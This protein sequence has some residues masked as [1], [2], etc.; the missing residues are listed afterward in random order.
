[1]KK[2][3]VDEYL[4]K[5]KNSNRHRN[6]LLAVILSLSMAVFFTVN[7][8]LRLTGI[9]MTG[10]TAAAQSSNDTA[11]STAETV[12]EEVTS[13]AAENTAAPENSVWGGGPSTADP[14]KTE[15]PAAEDTQ[16]FTLTSAEADGFTVTV[17]GDPSVLPY[18]AEE[19]SVSVKAQDVSDLNETQ[20]N[21]YNTLLASQAEQ[22]D[23]IYEAS[24]DE[25]DAQTKEVDDTTL[26]AAKQS[27]EDQNVVTSD[28]TA[29]ENNNSDT[30][31]STVTN[32]LFDVT[33]K[34]GD[35]A[36]E[37]KG[38][39]QVSIQSDLFKSTD[40]DLSIIHLDE[41]KNEAVDTEA[42]INT[43]EGTAVLKMDSFSTIVIANS[44]AKNMSWGD[45]VTKVNEKDG[46]NCTYKLEE[47]IDN[48]EKWVL[49]DSGDDVTI[50]LNGHHITFAGDNAHIEVKD[51]ATLTIVDTADNSST[52]ASKETVS[53]NNS[54][55]SKYYNNKAE[56]NNISES[57]VDKKQLIYYI[58]NSSVSDSD[59][60]KTTEAL[61]K[62][63]VTTTSYIS[64]N[65]NDK[66]KGTIYAENGSTVNV[67]GGLITNTAT[68]GSHDVFVTGSSTTLNVSGGYIA[69]VSS[70]QKGAGICA[71][72]GST[73]N[74]SG[75]VIA[76][77]ST[78]TGGGAVYL[79]GGN[80]NISHNAIISGNKYS[81]S[82]ESSEYSGGGGIYAINSA[83]IVI[84]G[85]YIT[86]NSYTGA[87]NDDNAT[88]FGG[89]AIWTN[90]DSEITI[91]DGQI[92]GNY[93][94]NGGGGLYIGS[95]NSKATLYLN[96]GIV[97]SNYCET[98]EGGGIRV[99]GAQ[100]SK[101]NGS[102]VQISG[103]RKTYITN[104]QTNS[105]TSW[106]GG[107]VFVQ[108]NG[109][110]S[111]TNVLITSNSADG[112]GG[113][114]ASCP[115]GNT[116]IN[117]S[118]AGIYSNTAAGTNFSKESLSEKNDDNQAKI[119]DSVSG[120]E[121]A[122]YFVGA[123]SHGDNKVATL[124]NSML[125]GGTSYWTGQAYEKNSLVKFQGTLGKAQYEDKNNLEICKMAALHAEPED[126]DKTNAIAAA[127]VFITGNTSHTNG[128][129][130]MTNGYVTVGEVRSSNK[131]PVINI[132]GTKVLQLNKIN[133]SIP[134]GKFNFE[135]LKTQPSYVNG[136]LKVDSNS[137]IKS[138]GCNASDTSNVS[139]LNFSEVSL[140]NYITSGSE[141]GTIHL[142]LVEEQ[143]NDN[144][145]EYS[146]V[147]YDI[148]IPYIREIIQTSPDNSLQ[149]E[150]FL[151][152]LVN[153]TTDNTQKLTV[154]KHSDSNTV[155]RVYPSDDSSNVNSYTVTP[156]KTEN[157]Y[158]DYRDSGTLYL[159]GDDYTFI[160]T[161]YS[162]TVLPSTGGIG[163]DW[164]ILGGCG[165]I[166]IALIYALLMD[167]NREG[168]DLG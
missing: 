70:D 155:T 83:K 64:S 85:G 65:N 143:G 92:T 125:G 123:Y 66:T 166:S 30:K 28:G 94:N 124:T 136:K 114:F 148:A 62:Y 122:D 80:L 46:I 137:I 41:V 19:M 36:V 11:E 107:G 60:T 127:I 8:G 35:E 144:D 165:L 130:I 1:M 6:K 61:V 129:G 48:T 154:E 5:R 37:S 141:S 147:Y 15:T 32:Y 99:A 26:D 2:N 146:Q 140:R 153:N 67:Q 118:Y 49:L 98:G 17:S 47:N 105:N 139:A 108:Q 167:S 59:S 21:L 22:T 84:D 158:Q 110:L 103:D 42:V 101:D 34:Y 97:A 134:E 106:G 50:D 102:L 78:S 87:R 151:Y 117:M 152:K 113:G 53:V 69:G 73:T 96:G 82:K 126:A 76:A 138:V 51:G 33:L 91:N 57:N 71:I 132:N 121:A 13:E 29:V 7:M 55:Q 18:P 74:L 16:Q 25:A 89:G 90:T 14:V 39:V 109:N 3:P 72:S 168:G 81:V 100:N 133:Q 20:K 116:D 135:L 38:E 88:R 52:S 9:T 44:E 120:S 58:T 24:A 31:S 77:N 95:W 63:T 161:K 23:Q 160:N 142:Y 131:Y 149:T 104:N 54:S 79:D 45:F 156:G 93:S 115:T 128:G 111:L 163:T 119:I 12:N 10:D 68:N 4:K 112:F 75:G 162:R 164:F 159:V 150:I 56:L 43:D 27:A 40:S 157:N 145:V 86:N